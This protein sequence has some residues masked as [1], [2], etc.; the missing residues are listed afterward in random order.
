MERVNFAISSLPPGTIKAGTY[1][2]N[3]LPISRDK[4]PSCN[5]ASLEKLQA[6]CDALARP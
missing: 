5:V 4:A 1:S 6:D 3:Y 2:T